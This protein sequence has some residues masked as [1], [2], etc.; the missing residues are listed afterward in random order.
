V[1]PVR[2]LVRVMSAWATAAPEASWIVPR[3]WAV[4]NWAS[5]EPANRAKQ[6]E[7]RLNKVRILN[8]YRVA[9]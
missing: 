5:R 6:S 2:R 7:K 1:T 3:T 4:S 9:V 8:F